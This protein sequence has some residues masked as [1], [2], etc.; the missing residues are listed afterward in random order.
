VPGICCRGEGSRSLH[1][2]YR[3]KTASGGIEDLRSCDAALAGVFPPVISTFPLLSRVA[4]WLARPV[5]MLPAGV[6][7]P[8]VGSN[9]SAVASTL[10][11][12]MSN[13]PLRGPGR[14]LAAW[15]DGR[16][17][18]AAMLPVGV[19]SGGIVDIH[20]RQGI[21]WPLSFIT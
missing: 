9:S 13:P 21:E 1:R 11:P 17:V 16:I 10:V 14:C 7:V 8:I 6:N 5:A 15:P 3:R 4:A 2:G 19:A 20:S 12:L 18:Q